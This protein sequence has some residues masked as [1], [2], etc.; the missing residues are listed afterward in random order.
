VSL[1]AIRF[2]GHDCV[3]L[4]DG[5]DEVVV[6]TSVGARILGVDGGRGNLLAVLPDAELARPDGGRFRLIGG[7]RLW[8]APEEPARTYASDDG[9]CAVAEIR[10]GVRVEAPTDAAGLRKAIEV[11]RSNGSWVVDHEIVNRSGVATTLAPWGVTQ[12]RGG[13]EA[14]L[15]L[16]P[17]HDGPGADRSL[18]LWPYTDP[19]DERIRLSRHTVRIRADPTGHRL[20]VGGAPSGGQVSYLLDGQVFEKHVSVDP[21][22]RYADRGAVVQVYVCDDFCE[23]ETLGPLRRL[24]PGAAATH[25]ERWTLG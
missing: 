3:R 12:V 1:E 11:R 24:A 23:L 19:G 17:A 7:H 4:R 16:P 25:R 14:R 10:G 13:G 6:T 21:D 20:K 15:S 2:E 22:G 18:V 5:A 8:A 9:P